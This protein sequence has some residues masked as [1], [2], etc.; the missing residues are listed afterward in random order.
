MGPGE[1]TAREVWRTAFEHA[2]Y[3]PA[4]FSWEG[5]DA[6]GAV[7]PDGRYTVFINELP[8]RV[9]VDSTPPEIGLRF[10]N[11]QA[12]GGRVS[13][14]ESDCRPGGLSRGQ[15][16]FLPLSSVA[17]DRVWHVVDERLDRWVFRHAKGCTT[18]SPSPSSC[19]RPTPRARPSSTGAAPACGARTA[20]PP[21]VASCSSCSTTF[22]PRA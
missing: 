15:G 19:R 5:R 20:G 13:V 9:E 3:G 16:A 17:A 14:S 8:F 11:L 1:P 4:S 21:T 12:A 22:G 10:E 2:T 18:V 7:V 6:S